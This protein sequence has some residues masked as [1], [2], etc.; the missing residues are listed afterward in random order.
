MHVCFLHDPQEGVLGARARL[1]QGAKVGPG[2]HLRD[3]Q[4]DGSGPR[5]PRPHPV[6]VPVAGALRRALMPLGADQACLGRIATVSGLLAG[7]G[8]KRA[9]RRLI[10]ETHRPCQRQEARPTR[11]AAIRL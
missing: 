7:S 2:P 3:R 4:L 5:V 8:H 6:A 11:R 1:E 9:W 10:V